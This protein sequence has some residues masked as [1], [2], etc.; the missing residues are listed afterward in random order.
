[1][2]DRISVPVND[3]ESRERFINGGT[4]LE[5]WAAPLESIV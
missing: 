1:M 3:L 4:D 2:E 5:E